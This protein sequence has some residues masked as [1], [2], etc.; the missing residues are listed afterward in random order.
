MNGKSMHAL[1]YYKLNHYLQ[2]LLLDRDELPFTYRH[3]CGLDIVQTKK[4]SVSTQFLSILKVN[5]N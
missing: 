2:T 3:T 5:C 1:C 4:D